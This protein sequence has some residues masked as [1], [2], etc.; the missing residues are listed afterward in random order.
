MPTAEQR[1]VAQAFNE[2]IGLNRAIIERINENAIIARARVLSGR[3]SKDTEL[4]SSY[5][6][7]V[8]VLSNC[9]RM[10]RMTAYLDVPDAMLL[11]D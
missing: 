10:L 5:L 3:L 1:Y 7:L 9:I 11:S 4:H 6:L 8:C 2:E